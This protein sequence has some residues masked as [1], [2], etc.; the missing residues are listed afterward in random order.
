MAAGDL[1]ATNLFSLGAGF[2]VQSSSTT[3]NRDIT[4]VLGANGDIQCQT[5]F[6]SVTTA[7]AEYEVC[8]A[9]S[10][11]LSLGGT[12]GGL[13]I[14]AVELS[15]SAGQAPRVTVE[16]ISFPGATV[17]NRT[18]AISQAVDIAAVAGLITGGLDANA[19]ATEI[20]HRWECEITQ[21]MGSDGQVAFAV[22]RTPKYTYSESGIG[23]FTGTPAITTP[24]GMVLE[25]FENSDSNQE[26][27]TY[28]ASF[29]NKLV[30]VGA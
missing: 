11:A 20:T 10:L 1:G 9:V 4:E 12:V 23:T 8:G 3:A 25:S 21:S 18:Y 28:T 26:T 13:I 22:S 30:S 5:P 19:E 14:R 7:T 6:N 27:D 24:A 2:N 16:G 17:T 15:H 29:V